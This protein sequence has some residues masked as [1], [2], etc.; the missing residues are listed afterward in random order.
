[1]VLGGGYGGGGQVGNS[2]CL[3]LDAGGDGSRGR[4]VGGAGGR[5]LGDI[6]GGGAGGRFLGDMTGAGRWVVLGRYGGGRA[7]AIIQRGRVYGFR[8]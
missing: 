8:A 4:W 6:A 1:M 7:E 2:R 3:W 5:F